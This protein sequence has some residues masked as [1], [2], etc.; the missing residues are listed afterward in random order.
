MTGAEL[1]DGIHAA[2]SCAIPGC[3]CLKP[4]MT[5]CPS[6]ADAQPSLSLSLKGGVALVHCQAGCDQEDVIAALREGGI[7]P[8][9]N[10]HAREQPK[11]QIIKTYDYHGP[12]GGLVFQV[13][14]YQPKDFRQRRPD[15]N[16]GWLWDMKGAKPIL[17]R[18][19][20][21]LHAP[22]DW[23][24]IM[25]EGEKDADTAATLGL[26]PEWRTAMFQD[27]EHLLATCTPMGAGKASKCDLSPL[28]DRRVVIIADDDEPGRK[29]A[30]D[31]VRLLSPRAASVKRLTLPAH[32]LTDYIN[33]GNTREDLE[34]LIA[35]AE[36]IGQPM[37]MGLRLAR[38]ADV[39]REEVRWRWLHRIPEAKLTLLE[40]DPGE[41]KSFLTLAFATAITLGIPL[42]GDI[43]EFPPRDVLLFSAEDGKA[44]TIRPRLEDMGAD[45]TR[46]YVVDGCI[47]EDGE[48]RWPSLKDDI[49]YIEAVLTSG[50]FGLVVLDPI[51]AYLGDTD[52]N[53]DTKI[54]AI[55]GPLAD[56]GERY[57]AIVLPLRHITK[58]PRDKAIYRG[59]GS[60]GY[61]GAARSVLLAGRNPDDEGERVVICIKHNLAPESP[62]IAYDIDRMGLFTWKGESSLTAEQI[63][64]A[65]TDEPPGAL[66]EAIRFL[67]EELQDG[68]PHRSKEILAN[69]AEQGISRRTLFRARD[70][71][72]VRAFQS[73]RQWF[74]E[75]RVPE[76][77][78][79]PWHSDAASASNGATSPGS[80]DPNER[81]RG[82]VTL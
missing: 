13:V 18:L 45:L 73:Q 43:G 20:E 3:R 49:G 42:P 80:A 24:V 55:L 38:L 34:K 23:P 30:E 33:A 32:D 5:H 26:R 39:Q 16:G 70:E 71:V 40:G 12:V 67:K 9:E 28:R 75:V 21:L 82:M 46:V 64:G 35:A 44:D 61:T 50:R 29:H 76:S 31:L 77:H 14:R 2:Q 66:G 27:C 37:R 11:R 62:A 4:G 6:H 10:S 48:K 59:I 78:T 41:G 57:N 8:P 69:A 74:W 68:Q 36:P 19:P 53:Q 72:G 22:R 1:L 65:S 56:L 79:T 60:I 15:G 7:W 63:L 25:V 47:G 54:R 81:T 52:G 58:S 51:N 17:Y